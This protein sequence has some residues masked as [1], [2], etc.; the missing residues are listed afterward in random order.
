VKGNQKMQF[1][2][3]IYNLFNTVQFNEVD[4]TA[5]FDAPGRQTD[6]NFG[7]VTSARNERRMQLSLRY[8]F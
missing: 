7:T 1:R 5:Q 2:W 6:V 4:R 8:S 3:E